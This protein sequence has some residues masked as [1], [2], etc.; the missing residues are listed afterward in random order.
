MEDTLNVSSPTAT[1]EPVGQNF[2]EVELWL[3]VLHGVVMSLFLVCSFTGNLIVLL[4][5]ATHKKLRYGAIVVCLGVCRPENKI[6]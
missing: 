1:N 6:L 5:V 2:D 3:R 4:L